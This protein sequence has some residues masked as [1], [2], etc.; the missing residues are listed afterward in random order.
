MTVDH[1]TNKCKLITENWNLLLINN[2]NH[3]YLGNCLEN[4]K[5]LSDFTAN[6][7][8]EHKRRCEI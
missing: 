1:A 6:K 4:V 3:T 7:F 5:R 2:I 8:W